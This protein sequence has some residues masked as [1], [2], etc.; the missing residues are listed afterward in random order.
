MH[1]LQPVD[2]EPF[3]RIRPASA[4]YRH[5]SRQS[6]SFAPSYPV[7]TCD[8]F[9]G[10]SDSGGRLISSTEPSMLW[11]LSLSTVNTATRNS[12]N[13]KETLSIQLSRRSG[14]DT[15]INLFRLSPVRYVSNHVMRYQA[16]GTACAP[17]W[18]PR[19]TAISNHRFDTWLDQVAGTCSWK[20][21]AMRICFGRRQPQW[22]RACHR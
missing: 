8:G 21:H 18:T 17:G 22:S 16:P 10:N 19:E 1:E 13:R 20:S 14:L 5:A 7:S 11:S 2:R 9:V 3:S 4:L 15:R 6:I 12:K